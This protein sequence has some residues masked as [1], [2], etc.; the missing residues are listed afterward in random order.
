MWR[1]FFKF[2][3]GFQLRQPLLWVCA[4]ILAL[5]AFGAASSDAVQVGGAIGNINRNAPLVTAKL[6]GAFSFLSM[7]VVTM[8]VA[9]PV[10][11]DHEVG[12]ADMLFATPM[13]K[14]DYLGGRFL[15]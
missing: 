15:A 14:R 13:K 3:L 5:L 10:L 2:D 6:L 4:L 8:F 12:I 9:A 7:L 11:R 1:E